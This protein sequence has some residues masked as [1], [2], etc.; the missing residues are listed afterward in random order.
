[1]VREAGNGIK[2]RAQE[3]IKTNFEEKVDSQVTL[4]RCFHFCGFNFFCTLS[5][6]IILN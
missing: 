4:L 1:M 3:K 6:K 2:S 5:L